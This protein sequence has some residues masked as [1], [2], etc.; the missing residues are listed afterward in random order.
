MSAEN[1]RIAVES[2]RE[3]DELKRTFR[4]GNR[5]TITAAY[6][7]AKGREARWLERSHKRTTLAAVFVTD[8]TPS[9]VREF[10]NDKRR[11]LASLVLNDADTLH[12][13]HFIGGSLPRIAELLGPLSDLSEDEVAERINAA[14]RSV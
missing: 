7:A 10:P 8:C 13:I 5:A 14:G 2:S 1:D 11:L 9:I 12:Q 4:S 6:Q 3:A